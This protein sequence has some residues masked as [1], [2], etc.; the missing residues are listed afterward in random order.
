MRVGVAIAIGL[1]MLAVK[2][3]AV[4]RPVGRKPEPGEMAGPV[5]DVSGWGTGD[6]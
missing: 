6:G 3:W 5:G 4:I 2:A 1:A